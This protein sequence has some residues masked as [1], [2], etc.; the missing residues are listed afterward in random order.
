MPPGPKGAIRT[1]LPPKRRMHPNHRGSKPPDRGPREEG[2]AG[3][4][5]EEGQ[6]APADGG[7]TA[8]VGI[9]MSQVFGRVY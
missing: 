2:G 4:Q 9:V 1:T 3:R 7:G 6:R 8:A 5:R